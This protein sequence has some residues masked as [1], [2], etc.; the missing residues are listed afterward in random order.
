MTG[1]AAAPKRLPFRPGPYPLPG[2]VHYAAGHLQQL[3]CDGRDRRLV[4]CASEML[5]EF[6]AADW[7]IVTKT[8]QK[9]ETAS[10]P[11]LQTRRTGGHV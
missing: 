8:T 3:A 7:G 4:P 11:W 2:E 6:G 9:L 5:H 1:A 10:A